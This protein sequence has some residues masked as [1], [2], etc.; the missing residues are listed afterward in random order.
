MVRQVNDLETDLGIP[1]LVTIP[2]T[3]T[4]AEKVKYRINS[5]MTFASMVVA[6][7]LCAAFVVLVVNGFE[8]TMELID[9]LT[10]RS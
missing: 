2:Q 7:A 10:A 8:G 6:V 5:L 1:V 9:E 4:T 3:Y